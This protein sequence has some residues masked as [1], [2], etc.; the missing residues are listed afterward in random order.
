MSSQSF[1]I[2]ISFNFTCFIWKIHRIFSSVIWIQTVCK[3]Y[4]QTTIV[5]KKNINCFSG[6][7]LKNK[8]GR[9]GNFVPEGL[10]P[11]CKIYGGGGGGNYVHIV[12]FIRGGLC[13]RCKN[14]GGGW[15]DG[16]LKCIWLLFHKLFNKFNITMM[17]DSF[18]HMTFILLWNYFEILF[19]ILKRL[20]YF[21]IMYAMLLRMLL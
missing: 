14:H 19:L 12:K 5:A 11:C 4:Q 15:G 9:A 8:W 13:P 2:S 10:C 21:I 7:F 3:G 20:R 16:G 17:L 1:K 6:H 18:H